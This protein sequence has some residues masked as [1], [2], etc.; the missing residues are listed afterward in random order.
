MLSFK[1]Q[2][3]PA[4]KPAKEYKFQLDPFQQAAVNFIEAGED[5]LSLAITY[6]Q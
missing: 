3:K 5:L 6:I 2:A 4:R 1:F